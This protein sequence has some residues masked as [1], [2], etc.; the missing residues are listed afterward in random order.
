MTELI[1]GW[2]YSRDKKGVVDAI[3]PDGK[4][5]KFK[6]WNA[7]WN[8]AHGLPAPRNSGPITP[9][10]LL[11]IGG[12]TAVA[13]LVW[14]DSSPEAKCQ[15]IHFDLEFWEGKQHEYLDKVRQAKL[16]VQ[17]GRRADLHTVEEENKSNLA[18]FDWIQKEQIKRAKQYIA[19]PECKTDRETLTK[20]VQDNK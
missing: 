4:L 1:N 10:A 14:P 16:D 11:I 3:S 19:I 18:M 15:S 6:N 13:W 9:K 7:F 5:H 20:M 8:M 2:A 12:I 17:M